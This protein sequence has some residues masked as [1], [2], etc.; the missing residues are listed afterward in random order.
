M[1]EPVN[2]IYAADL[3]KILKKGARTAGRML[4]DLE[5]EHGEAAVCR[6]GREGRERYTWWEALEAFTELRRADHEQSFNVPKLISTIRRLLSSV[7]GHDNRLVELE[8][9]VEEVELRVATICMHPALK[10]S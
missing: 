1:I 10:I 8:G 4:E 5:A 9:R 7:A 3:A 6:E 2:R